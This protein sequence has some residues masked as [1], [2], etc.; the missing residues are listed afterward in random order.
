ML[1]CCGRDVCSQLENETIA[2]ASSVRTGDRSQLAELYCSNMFSMSAPP[3]V[4]QHLPLLASFS[5]CTIPSR[6]ARDRHTAR[7]NWAVHCKKHQQKGSDSAEQITAVVM[8]HKV[9]QI[10]FMRLI[11]SYLKI[12]SDKSQGED[13]KNQMAGVLAGVIYGLICLYISHIAYANMMTDFGQ[14]GLMSPFGSGMILTSHIRP[15]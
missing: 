8:L 1:V 11:C 13:D 12:T 10:C 5:V 3:L 9:T 4:T 2:G 15:I 7:L 14:E 6:P